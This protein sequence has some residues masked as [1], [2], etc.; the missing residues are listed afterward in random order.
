MLR[1]IFKA[2]GGACMHCVKPLVTFKRMEDDLGLYITRITDSIPHVLGNFRLLCKACWSNYHKDP[3]LVPVDWRWMKRLAAAWI[4]H[5]ILVISFLFGK[6][7]WASSYLLQHA[8]RKSSWH[9][10]RLY[11]AKAGSLWLLF[12]GC[13]SWPLALLELI[14]PNRRFLSLKH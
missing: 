12:G 11:F 4:V 9:Y 3:T 6:F 5:R 1:Y 10:H 13:L 14:R 2:Q 8:V 7:S